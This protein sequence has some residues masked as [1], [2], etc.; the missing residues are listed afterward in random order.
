MIYFFYLVLLLLLWRTVF[1]NPRK[2]SGVTRQKPLLLGHRGVRGERPENTVEAFQL[3]FESGLD[4]IECD[5]QRTSD[6][7]LVLFHDFAIKD[8]KE[9]KGRR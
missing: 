4:G 6:G 9:G 2:L 8:N 5:V 1:W 7:Q 3:A